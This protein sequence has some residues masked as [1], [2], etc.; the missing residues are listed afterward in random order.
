MTVVDN[1]YGELK[2]LCGKRGT[3]VYPHLAQCPRLLQRLPADLFP[4]D[5]LPTERMRA[6]YLA[7]HEVVK[8]A[9]AKCEGDAKDKLAHDIM[10]AAAVIGIVTET[11]A[12]FATKEPNERAAR[13]ENRTE[14]MEIAG[15]WLDTAIK[16][17]NFRNHEKDCVSNF[18]DALLE[19]LK[20]ERA[21]RFI[22]TQITSRG[23]SEVAV[24]N[25]KSKAIA[26]SPLAGLIYI[27]REAYERYFAELL[28][29]DTRLIAFVGLPGMGKTTLARRLTIGEDGS[30]APFIRTRKG[31]LDVRDLQTALRLC[32]ISVPEA[33]GQDA[34]MLF[35]LL[36]TDVNAPRFVVVDNLESA[37]QLTDL[38][39]ST[40][41]S[42]TVVAT[43][44]DKGASSPAS[45]QFV[46]VQRLWR[47]E[48]VS[49]VLA[50]LPTVGESAATSLASALDDYPLNLVYACNL[51]NLGR[52]KIEQF[53][54]D[55]NSLAQ[56]LDLHA[57][58]DGK[59]LSSILGK[60]VVLV[61]QQDRLATQLLCCLSIAGFML[62]GVAHPFLF[63][64]LRVNFDNDLTLTRY[65]QALAVL[66]RVSLIEHSDEL[67]V[68]IH[69]HVWKALR[70]L[71]LWNIVS[72]TQGTCGLAIYYSKSVGRYSN[73]EKLRSVLQRIATDIALSVTHELE[74]YDAFARYYYQKRHAERDVS[75][76]EN[77]LIVVIVEHA[78]RILGSMAGTYS[79]S[80]V[81]VPKLI[82]TLIAEIPPLDTSSSESP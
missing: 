33:Y 24:T 17:R 40:A 37:E 2:A 42:P 63:N 80:K 30:E 65:H 64:Y 52:I 81:D 62:G 67:Y 69:P 5:A 51:V 61:D 31:Q 6:L 10:A 36:L 7:L 11:P 44:L 73:D 26:L 16:G 18:R 35:S 55:I 71:F 48:A 19:V 20:D 77:L 8:R 70:G 53:C 1:E 15:A 28:A 46:P 50:Y 82:A 41:Y 3:D 59:R 22:A 78:R 14:R 21:M 47:T 56:S 9:Y 54:A 32:N 27:R 23:R 72:V 12:A 60:I 76:E 49:L 58:S 4:E 43:C 25:P 68:Y 34:L 79:K 66:R 45:C 38:L 75:A 13:K 29:D 74:I 39:P 57:L